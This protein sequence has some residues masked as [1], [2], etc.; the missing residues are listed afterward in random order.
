MRACGEIVANPVLNEILMDVNCMIS[1]GLEADSI[2]EMAGDFM[3]KFK[4]QEENIYHCKNVKMKPLER[5]IV[6]IDGGMEG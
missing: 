3:T 4:I 1:E 5:A 2:Y 6:E